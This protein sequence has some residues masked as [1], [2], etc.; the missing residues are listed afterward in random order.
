M[1]SVRN[2]CWNRTEIASA[3]A[4]INI[5]LSAVTHDVLSSPYLTASMYIITIYSPCVTLWLDLLDHPQLHTLD[6]RFSKQAPACILS[7]VVPVSQSASIF[8]IYRVTHDCVQGGIQ[9]C[10]WNQWGGR[11][12]HEKE[13]YSW[14]DA[15]WCILSGKGGCSDWDMSP[16][17][18][19][20]KYHSHYVT[21][22]LILV[23]RWYTATIFNL[24]DFTT[25]GK[26][27]SIQWRFLLWSPY[28]GVGYFIV[29]C[30]DHSDQSRVIF[31]VCGRIKG[32][33]EAARCGTAK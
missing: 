18:L 31:C 16:V 20:A 15:F 12:R 30:V 5:S 7:K 6:R 2:T 21:I 14:N 26:W 24:H 25:M 8:Y 4:S 3:A 29:H 22:A 13:F 10:L 28:D 17:L 33:V 11:L 1:N 27:V 23:A 32:G 9:Y 19:H